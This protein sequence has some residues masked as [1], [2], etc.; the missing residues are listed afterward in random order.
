MQID[1]AK[2]SGEWN[3]QWQIV[4]GNKGERTKDAPLFPLPLV[5][6]AFHDLAAA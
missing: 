6:V 1:L 2:T 4:K 5:K 3:F